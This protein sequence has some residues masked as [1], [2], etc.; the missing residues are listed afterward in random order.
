MRDLRMLLEAMALK[1]E[2]DR[3]LVTPDTI[4]SM[5]F[6]SRRAKGSSDMVGYEVK[7]VWAPFQALKDM[8][9]KNLSVQLG[10][11]VPEG[12]T[13][14]DMLEVLKSMQAR[15]TK[16]GVV[17]QPA[18]ELQHEVAL[19][20]AAYC[21]RRFQGKRVDLVV[22]PQSSSRFANIFGSL[23]ADMLRAEHVPEG[24]VKS[25]H[26]IYLDM[27][28]HVKDTKTGRDA[29]QDVE[30]WKEKLSRGKVPS[31]RSSFKPS[32]RQHLRGFMA[33]SD[34]LSPHVGEGKRVLI[35]DDIV[36]TG[37][38]QADSARALTDLGF[39]VV[40]MVAA[41]KEQSGR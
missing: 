12:V 17:L 7:G 19:Q 24:V 41:V 27:P 23:L 8:D 18:P 40:G 13:A 38:T 36:T 16:S 37:S 28:D 35:V 31:L 32:M 21:A 6:G 2:R 25:Q 9:A 10:K 4:A 39:E 20:A 5:G 26:N 11:P 3:W 15:K 14:N 29:Q 30:D 34:N 33:A 22:S 1:P